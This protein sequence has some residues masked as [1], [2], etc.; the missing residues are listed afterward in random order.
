MTNFET[1][2]SCMNEDVCP[3]GS[4]PKKVLDRVLHYVPGLIVFGLIA[5]YYIQL[6]HMG[7]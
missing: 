7:V 6:S 5:L 3:T 2:K 1:Q 4:L